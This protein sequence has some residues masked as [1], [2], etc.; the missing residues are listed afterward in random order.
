MD[1]FAPAGT[2]DCNCTLSTFPQLIPPPKLTYRDNSTILS[3]DHIQQCY[4]IFA[5]GHVGT[6]Y[7]ILYWKNSRRKSKT[8]ILR[9]VLIVLAYILHN[10][11]TYMIYT[12]YINIYIIISTSYMISHQAKLV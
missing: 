12:L 1:S 9:I 8:H 10:V 6:Q 5:R 11:H 2:L 4:I 3:F 7:Y